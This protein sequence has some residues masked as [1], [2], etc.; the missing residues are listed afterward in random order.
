M[1]KFPEAK[2]E[3][4][5]KTFAN[6]V[7]ATNS[8][9]VSTEL[10]ALEPKLSGYGLGWFLRDYKGRKLVGHSGGVAGFVTRVLL[11]RESGCGHSDECRRG[12]A[13]ESIL[14]HVLDSYLGGASQ[15]YTV[16]FKTVEDQ[17]Q[18][19]AAQTM[20]KAA[21]ARAAGSKPSLP[22]E[23]YTGECSDPWYGKM[24]IIQE[25]GG[26]VLT[27]ARTTKGVA[28]LQHWQYDTFKAH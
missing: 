21:T 28:D 14:Y 11:V 10:K 15:D 16:A 5:A 19:A 26:L 23:K 12:F 18:K 9:A 6:D 24:T 22:M 2:R 27:L 20:K 13:F 7:G 25:S 3:F 1:G 4:S 17:Q 8:C